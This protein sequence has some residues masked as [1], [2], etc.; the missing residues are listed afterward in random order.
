M[1]KGNTTT[2]KF[3][4]CVMNKKINVNS[5]VTLGYGKANVSFAVKSI[6]Q[7]LLLLLLAIVGLGL[8]AKALK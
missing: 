6:D 8:L 3:N 4:F 7:R 2:V 5:Q 1:V